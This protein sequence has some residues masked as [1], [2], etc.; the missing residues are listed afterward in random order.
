MSAEEEQL[1]AQTVLEATGGVLIQGDARAS[2]TGVSTDS[3]SIKPGELF[4]ALRGGNFD[5]HRFFAEAMLRGGKG[6]VVEGEIEP[7]PDKTIP[8]IKVTTTLQALGDLAHLWRKRHPIPLVAV[9]GSNGKTTTKEMAAGIL[10]KR[11]TVMKNPGN[12][13][14]LIGLPLSLLKMNS[15]YQVAIMEMGMNRRGEILRLTHIAEPDLGIL[16][17]IGP[18][19]LEGL[20]SIEGVMEAKGELLQGMGARGR[21][22]FN[23]DDPRVVQLSNRFAGNKTS[24]GTKNPADWM[25]ADIR[26]QEDGRVFFQIQGPA[27]RIPVSLRII[28]RHQIYNA[29]AAAAATAHLGLG[30][31]DIKD[32]LEAFEPPPMRMELTA[33]GKGITIIN[34]A[35]NANPQSM[36]AALRTL[37]EVTG[38]RKIAVLGDMWELGEYAEQAHRELGRAIHEK[39]INLLFL[40]GRFAS[41]V[42]E[43]ATEAGMDPRA[44]TIG[45]DHHAV[46]LHLSGILKEGDW[47]LIK[48][49]RIMKMEEIIKELRDAL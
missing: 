41:Q 48:G 20:G 9:V 38:K 47:V 17:T 3:R 23:A 18:V 32:G 13:N 21:L 26:I 31:E 28:G 46:S 27:G 7:A 33:L 2:F 4:F 16:T 43:G 45:K 15:T 11:Y 49:S 35:Y 14:N 42:A 25:A 6:A 5:G 29:L 12:L 44:V 39:G 37:E 10:G 34:D 30:M 8:I 1:S 22:I 19:H 36:D 24:F 40:L